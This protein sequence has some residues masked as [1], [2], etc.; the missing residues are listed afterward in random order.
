MQYRFLLLLFCLIS[1]C[2]DSSSGYQPATQKYPSEPDQL[3]AAMIDS[4]QRAQRSVDPS[5]V[6]VFLSQQRA[7]AYKQQIMKA[8]GL[9]KANLMVMYGFEELK[10]GNTEAAIQAFKDVTEFVQ[11]ME[12]PGKEQTLLEVQKLLALSYLRL[13]EQENCILNHTS[14]SCVLP[15]ATAGQHKKKEGSQQAMD[16]YIEILKKT[17]DDLTSRYLLNIAAM[18]LGQFPNGVPAGMRMPEGYF[19]SKVD[20]PAFTDIAMGMGLDR[21]SLAGG[22]AIDDFDRDGHLDIIHS[23]WGFNDQ[24]SYH[25]NNGDGTFTDI[26]MTSGLKGVTGGLNLRHADYNNDG[27]TDI[28]LLRGAWFRD[29]GRIPN[30]LLRNNGDGTFTDVTV[31]A[32]IY[33]KRPTQNAV[34]ADF[35]LD[36][37]LDLFI[38]NESIPE[39]GPAFNFPSELYHNQGDGTFKEVIAQ[40]GIQVNAFIKGS[41]GGDINNDG[42]PDLYLSILNG[43]NQLFLNVSNGDGIKFKN[44]TGTADVGEPF[45]SFPTWMYDYNNDG[46]L[47][48]FVSAYSDGSEDLPGKVLRAYGT[49]DDPFRPR[50]Y[51]NNGD[52]T[53]TEVSA[54]MQLTEPA[55]TMGS[56]Y[57]DLDGDGYQDI[58]LGTGEPNLKSIVPNK[59]YWNRGG[60]KYD[61]ITYA[62][63]FGNI[64]KGHGAGFGDLD[65][66]GD[67]DVYIVMGGSFEGDVYQNIFF[68]NPIG[69]N[70]NWIVLQ[71]EGTTSSRSAIDARVEIEVTENGVTRKIHDVV[72]TGS[73]FGGSSLQLEV[74]LGKAEKIN[75]ITIH[76]PSKSK[77]VQNFDAPAMN[78]AYTLKEGGDLKEIS[79]TKI[80]FR[81]QS[82]STHEHHH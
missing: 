53:F 3:T 26:A 32:G 38:G 79:Y 25:H 33:S 63:G 65:H 36:G 72:S 41:A 64:Q 49:T 52:L 12:I 73:S 14:A 2:H 57:G 43:T 55:F 59:M 18:T 29:Q 62:G 82:G 13:G 48:I 42:L 61:D 7:D 15:I 1:A 21:R 34:W 44:I 66:D 28:L 56:N 70:N 75:R 76:W 40:S 6:T 45:V 67:Q 5:K 30:S 78:K 80:P 58:F 54:S 69:Q 23:S 16:I 17:P 35:D 60:E 39:A 31:E 47:D 46:W 81:P 4:V 37:N 77:T 11:P 20:F 22:I 9:P 68:E 74:G 50:L 24:I 51:R 19:T 71:L 27:Y 10:A 8:S